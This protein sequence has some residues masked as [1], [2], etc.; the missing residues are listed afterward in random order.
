MVGGTSAVL[1]R[2]CFDLM[3]CPCLISLPPLSCLS[4]YAVILNLQADL[5][6]SILC[7]PSPES[8]PS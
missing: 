7:I 1:A 8:H 5:S 2:L 3:L 6:N 4:Q